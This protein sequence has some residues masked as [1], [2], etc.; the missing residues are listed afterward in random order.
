MPKREQKCGTHIH[1]T[2]GSSGKWKLTQLKDIAMGIIVYETNVKELLPSWRRNNAYCKR[3]TSSSGELSS[4]PSGASAKRRE[5]STRL[6][7][8][9]NETELCRFM[10]ADRYVLWNFFNI[11]ESSKSGTIEFRGG[12]GL[13]GP[14]R[15]KRWIAFVVAFI[16]FVLHEVRP[17]LV[18]EGSHRRH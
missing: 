16:D 1:I 18:Q 5:L 12:R 11:R 14:H 15:T 6:S 10:Q 4:L 9:T 7:R 13:R 3:N 8:V 2:P 17:S